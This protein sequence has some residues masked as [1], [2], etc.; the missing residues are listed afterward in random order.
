VLTHLY[1][2]G[3]GEAH[4]PSQSFVLAA[5]EKHERLHAMGSTSTHADEYISLSLTKRK[6]EY[7]GPHLES[8]LMHKDDDLSQG[9]DGLF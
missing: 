6:D 3:A 2:T 4:I 1:P 5:E 7:L 8:R 9:D